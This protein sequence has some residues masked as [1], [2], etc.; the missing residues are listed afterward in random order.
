MESVPQKTCAGCA[1]TLPTT[2]FYVV[3]RDTGSCQ[4][5]CKACCAEDNRARY[6]ARTNNPDRIN[7]KAAPPKEDKACE[8]CGVEARFCVPAYP[9]RSRQAPGTLRYVPCVQSPR[10]DHAP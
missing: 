9:E 4:P 5:K 3:N 2:E 8:R 1:R 10:C 6:Y 7:R